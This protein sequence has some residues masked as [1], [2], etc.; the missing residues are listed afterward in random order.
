MMTD[1]PCDELSDGLVTI[2]LFNARLQRMPPTQRR[3]AANVIYGKL[4]QRCSANAEYIRLV[5]PTIDRILGDT[6]KDLFPPVMEYRSRQ[7]R[8]QY[9]NPISPRTWTLDDRSS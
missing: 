3:I 9:D 1:D 2:M 8:E 5:K 6:I 4:G 7:L